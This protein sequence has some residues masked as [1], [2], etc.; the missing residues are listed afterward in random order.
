[1]AAKSAD[2]TGLRLQ[3]EVKITAAMAGA[4]FESVTPPSVWAISFSP[5]G[6]YLAFGVQFVRTKDSNFP[7]YLLIVSPDN[8]KALLK[9]FEIPRHPAMRG[10]SRIVWSRDSRFLAV[11]PYGDWNRAAVVDLDANELHVVRDR[12]GVSWCGGAASLLPGPLLAQKCALANG[13]GSVVRLLRLDGTAAL[14]WTFPGTVSLLDISPDE[15][16]L[17]L[18]LWGSPTKSASSRHEIAILD[19]SDRGEV[20]RWSLADAVAYGGFFANSGAVFCTEP[21]LESVR[22]KQ[23]LVC[24][25]IATGSE[26]SRRTLPL[27]MSVKGVVADK[28]IVG[29]DNILLFPF[30]LFGTDNV[31]TRTDEE[32]WDSQMRKEIA[33]W[34][35]NSQWVL[36]KVDAWWP[37]AVS[38][39]GQLVAEGGSGLL[40]V[41]HVSQ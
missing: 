1:M 18:D 17:A 30:P 28:F 32:L 6:K 24:R 36:P 27:G 26:V 21:K 29:H 19:L 40:R 16:T 15:R 5:D 37:S 14:S 9:K 23:E 7:S 10:V 38:A 34:R 13:A 41:Y 25:D 3:A 12:A 2:V 33:S 31:R 20:R 35:V 8:P 22:S 4:P 11:T 39:D